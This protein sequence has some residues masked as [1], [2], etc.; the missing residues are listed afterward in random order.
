MDTSLLSLSSGFE[1]HLLLA[2][3]LI[4]ITVMCHIF[5]SG[6]AYSSPFGPGNHFLSPALTYP[7]L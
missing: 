3:G 1:R 4:H 6:T 2:F 7:G 5:A